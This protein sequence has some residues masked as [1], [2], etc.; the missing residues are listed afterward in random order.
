MVH[1]QPENFSHDAPEGEENE[2]TTAPTNP[3]DDPAN[4]PIPPSP[5]SESQQLEQENL[6][7]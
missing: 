1:D 2:P 3:E 4:Y 6:P 5:P 7:S